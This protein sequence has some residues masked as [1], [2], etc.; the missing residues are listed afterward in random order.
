MT[1]KT[2]TKMYVITMVLT[3]GR[4]CRFEYSEER[5]AKEQYL[6]YTTVGVIN[7]QIIKKI[8]FE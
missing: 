8:T 1:K 4:T 2:E 3:E 5:L 6:Y 7:N